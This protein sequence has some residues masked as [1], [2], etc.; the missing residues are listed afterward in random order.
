VKHEADNKGHAHLDENSVTSVDWA[1]FEAVLFDLDGVITKSARLH[2]KAWQQVFDEFL[3]K[4]AAESGAPFQPFDVLDDYARYVDGKPRH[5]GIKSFLRSRAIGLPE[6]MADDPSGGSTIN[7]LAKHKNAVFLNILQDRGIGVYQGAIDL[8]RQLRELGCRLAVV[9]SSRN[10][11][12][13]LQAA[14]LADLFDVQV[15]GIVARQLQLDGKPAPDTFL[16][17]AHQLGV[18]AK[19]AVV[20]EDSVAGVEAGRAGRFALVIGVE[21]SSEP[22]RL[23]AHGANFVVADLATLIPNG[24]MKS[25]L[26][27]LPLALQVFDDLA[28]KIAEKRLVV[29]LDYDGTLTKIVAR[30]ELAVLNEDMRA[31]VRRLAGLCP[32]I[33]ISG[34]KRSDLAHLVDLP[35]VIFAG[36]HGFDISGPRGMEVRHEEGSEYIPVVRRAARAIRSRLRGIDGAIVEDKIYAVAV[37]Y[38]LVDH[39]LAPDV[40]SA[41]DAVLGAE[42]GLRKMSGKKVFELLP[43][44]EWNK[45]KALLWLLNALDLGGPDVIPIYLG[46]DVTDRDAFKV[47]TD[48]GIGILVSDIHEPTCAHYRLA[49]TGEV[50][51]FLQRLGDL[52]DGANSG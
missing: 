6:G 29:F 26:G 36:S 1:S 48:R 47:L 32:V 19:R 38:R 3:A 16:E 52:I 42:R 34:R 5:E 21:R 33:V 43:D 20:V 2:A 11:R 46:D 25:T 31:T 22:K 24:G 35:S 9:S 30:P 18:I 7:G 4:R 14:G 51:T 49:N 40:E 17:A 28:A 41:V 12:A 44:I 37:H 50:R 39:S 45:G 23:Q 13:V 8:I 10:C 27:T 15:D